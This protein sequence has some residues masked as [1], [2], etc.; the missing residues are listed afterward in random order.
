MVINW[1]ENQ[2]ID[3]GFNKGFNQFYQG[4]PSIGYQ[5]FVI[6]R[7]I[8]IYTIPTA[9]E[10]KTQQVPDKIAVVGNGFKN[11]LKSYYADLNVIVAPAFRF[12]YL[13]SRNLNRTKGKTDGF[14]R[15][16]VALPISVKASNDIIKLLNSYNKHNINERFRW[17]IKPHPSLNINDLEKLE[18]NKKYFSFSTNQF[19]EEITKAEIYVGNSSSTGLEALTYGIPVIIVGSNTGLT[20][21]PIPCSISKK[22]WQ[23]C[24]TPEE[25]S[26]ALNEFCNR[27][28]INNNLMADELL[29]EYFEPVTKKGVEQLINV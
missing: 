26:I 10:V 11:I 19:V 27:A 21:N 13:H 29:N 12:S 8:N 1:F 3:R 14:R 4:I 25:L 5:G 17:I 7:D 24:Y 6:P 18:I 22:Y 9:L 23:I 28:Q 20:E 2:I 16:L 15:I